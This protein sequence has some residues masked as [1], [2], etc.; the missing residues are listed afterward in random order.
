MF[1]CDCVQE[2]QNESDRSELYSFIEGL[3]EIC[4]VRAVAYKDLLSNKV[5]QAN[6]F[7]GWLLHKYGV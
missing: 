4:E 7:E 5:G 3:S 1:L 2:H 6:L